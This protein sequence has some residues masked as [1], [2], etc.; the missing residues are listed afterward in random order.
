MT[1]VEDEVD[2]AQDAREPVGELVVGGHAAGDSGDP[3]LA[4]ARTNRWYI[5]GSVVR[6]AGQLRHLEAAQGAEGERQARLQGRARGG[7]R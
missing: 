3:D 6:N 5:A 2:D 7:S 1:L 4:P